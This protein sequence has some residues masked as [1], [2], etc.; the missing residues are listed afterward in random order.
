[1]S[2]CQL[3]RIDRFS[4]RTDLI[5][6]DQNAVGNPLV[7][8][9]L[10]SFHIGHEEVVTHQLDFVTEFIGQPFPGLPVIFGTAIFDAAD[11]VLVAPLRHEVDHLVTREF[12]A[13]D[14]VL[15]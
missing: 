13:V 8:S 12:F 6:L 10:Q 3:D 9:T 15:G 2:S 14:G 5:H 11:R 4:E 7:D 1:M